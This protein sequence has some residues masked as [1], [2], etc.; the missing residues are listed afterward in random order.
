MLKKEVEIL[1]S[2][3]KYLNYYDWKKAQYV[4][5]CA[6]KELTTLTTE[7]IKE[8]YKENF[9][10]FLNLLLYIDEFLQLKKWYEAKQYLKLQMEV[11]KEV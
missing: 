1:E 8:E 4:V 9:D 6:I 2:I 7:Q 5:M 10:R 3:Y 11:L